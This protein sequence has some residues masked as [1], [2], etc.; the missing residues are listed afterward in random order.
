M[1]TFEPFA[2]SKPTVESKKV[3]FEPF[4]KTVT[5]SVSTDPA[6]GRA[7][8]QDLY[9]LQKPATISAPPPE[10]PLLKKI[11]TT[12]AK[13]SAETSITFIDLGLKSE[14][15]LSDLAARH[16]GL[17]TK[18]VN[19][20]LSSFTENL[21]EP[22]K[23]KGLEAWQTVINKGSGKIIDN[24]Q[25]ELKK[26]QE[27]QF[28][29]PSFE[30]KNATLKEKLSTQLP[31]TVLHLGP[32]VIG[33]L[34]WYL[35]GSG[36]GAG[37]QALAVADDIKGY[38]RKDG[39]DENLSDV[40]GLSAGLT[41]GIIDK[42][43]FDKVF[44]S[45]TLSDQFIK[46]FVL[47]LGKKAF[48]EGGTEV[49][50]EDV[51]LA[52]EATV[53]DDITLDEVT[54]RNV[55]SFLGG[56]L[57]GGVGSVIVDIFNGTKNQ[58]N[59]SAQQKEPPPKDPPSSFVTEKKPPEPPISQNFVGNKKSESGQSLMD[60]MKS[61]E[62]FQ[63]GID[64]IT[65]N[66]VQIGNPESPQ[67]GSVFEVNNEL[68]IVRDLNTTNSSVV[69]YKLPMDGS[70]TVTLE[71]VGVASLKLVQ[72][73]IGTIQ[74][75]IQNSQIPTDIPR[76]TQFVT[77][78]TSK[79]TLSRYFNEGDLAV[80]FVKNIDTPD[81][82][83]A[84]GRYTPHMIELVNNPHKT[85]ADHEAVHA[86]LDLFYNEGEKQA[87]MDEAK[88]QMGDQTG[89]AEEWVADRFAAF[90]QS[91]ASVTGAIRDFFDRVVSFLRRAFKK[92]NPDAVAKLFEDIRMKN[93]P[94][95]G[96]ALASVQ[97]EYYQKPDE[98]TAKIFTLP[99]VADR[100]TI[101]RTHLSDLM[102][103]SKANLKQAEFLL[104]QD[105]LNTQFKDDQKIDVQAFKDAVHAQLLPLTRLSMESDVMSGEALRYEN[106]V[107][108]D[109]I[110]GDVETYNEN[111]Y[112]SPIETKA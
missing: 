20:A 98:L 87:V 85:T 38:A 24:A 4:K 57:G 104:L 73:D 54:E 23:D 35:L 95:G 36:V 14:S 19:P 40:L 27:S 97:T 39:M 48:I 37:V 45:K 76:S 1:A 26:L 82:S 13:F 51:Q 110:R 52:A 90:V 66:S 81:G 80:T 102:K 70:P 28:L 84:F 33:S 74:T 75:A 88:K 21:P 47:R 11:G 17:I 22:I 9:N 55:M 77:N 7:T 31:E 94:V 71:S 3:P 25:G 72:T 79:K 50:Q 41:V 18:L 10:P 63:T 62:R 65:A 64:S 61:K 5:P 83:V 30:Y 101:G 108:S 44:G 59:K 2:P 106:I 60:K 49:L 78:E 53:R 111:I 112:E 89:N 34:A 100:V 91:R 43:G 68:F 109:D 12:L 46:G 8:K 42:L 105:V 69:G 29:Q 32:S 93:R 92:T 86:Y 99:E 15:M 16:P 103:S 107:L 96:K 58:I 67:V 6:I 56:S